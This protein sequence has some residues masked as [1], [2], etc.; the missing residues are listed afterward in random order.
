[1][2]ENLKAFIE[3]ESGLG[4]VELVLLILILAGLAIVFKGKISAFFTDLTAGLKASDMLEDVK[5]IN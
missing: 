2:K 4:T 5:F 3:D 1:M